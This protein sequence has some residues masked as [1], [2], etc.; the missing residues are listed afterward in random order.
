[1]TAASGRGADP[2]SRAGLAAADADGGGGII[3]ISLAA[4]V[5]EYRLT[6]RTL[7]ARQVTLLQSDMDA[8]AALYEQRRIPALRQAMEFRAATDPAEAIFLLAGQAAPKLAGNL[9]DWPPTL[10]APRPGDF[11]TEGLIRFGS[12]SATGFVDY[13]GVTRMLPGGFPLLVARGT[14][15]VDETLAALRRLIWLVGAGAGG[16]GAGG[17]L[18]GRRGW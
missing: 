4:M 13:Q 3:L 10:A 5:A 11:S 16:G 15:A 14:G 7:T 2:A 18:G 9:D 17:G 6:A 12:S 8:F 1:M